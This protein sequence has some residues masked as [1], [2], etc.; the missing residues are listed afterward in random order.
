[1]VAKVHVI[2]DDDAVRDSLA[3]LL[4]TYGIE[5]AAYRSAAEAGS[6]ADR[7]DRGCLI[8]DL[9]LPGADGIGLVRDLR[10]AGVRLPAI[11][12]VDA[13]GP[14][15][16]RQA[17]QLGACWVEKPVGGNELAGLV[18]TLLRDALASAV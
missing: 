15:L 2:A 5:V 1:M 14:G 6:N 16:D 17:R 18:E 9:H 8:V 12:C 3:T 13:G 11:L 4:E 10:A 7:L